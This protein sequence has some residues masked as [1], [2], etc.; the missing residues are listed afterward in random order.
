MSV[1]TKIAVSILAAVGIVGLLT[2]IGIYLMMGI[3]WQDYQQA[4]ASHGSHL[5]ER[6]GSMLFRR[7]L[8]R[9]CPACGQG[10]ISHSIFAMN[11]TCPACGVTFWRA[12]GEWMG[13]SVINYGA[14]FGGALATWAVLVLFDCSEVVQLALSAT[15]AIVAVLIIAPWSRSF[16]TLLLFLNGEVK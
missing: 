8:A 3:A 9:K 12:E 15:A 10:A 7:A 1:N 6:T 14:T 16:W 4:A 11:T 13:P 5:S 2:L